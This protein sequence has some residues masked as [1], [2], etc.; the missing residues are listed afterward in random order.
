MMQ[1]NTIQDLIKQA[2]EARSFAHAPY[3]HFRVGA[4]ILAADGTVFKGCNVENSSYSVTCC[5]ERVALFSAVAQGRTSF[6]AIAI[7]A[8][9]ELIPPC[10]VCRQALADFAPDLTVI[11]ASLKGTYRVMSMRDLLPEPFTPSFLNKA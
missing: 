1:D 8:D 4:A 7:V 10:G 5:A 6:K 11:L 2:I 9:D 3:S